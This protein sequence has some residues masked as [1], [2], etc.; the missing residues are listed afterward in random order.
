MPT[1]PNP[2]L[3]RAAIHHYLTAKR[4]LLDAIHKAGITTIGERFIPGDL[5]GSKEHP[6]QFWNEGDEACLAMLWIEFDADGAL[7]VQVDGREDIIQ[8]YR[9]RE[10]LG[11]KLYLH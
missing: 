6:V 9:T 4:A 5:A 7:S 11:E 8:N 10:G 2:D 1:T 3:I